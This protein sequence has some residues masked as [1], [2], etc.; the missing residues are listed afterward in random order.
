M[1]TKNTEITALVQ[2]SASQGIELSKA[3][4]LGAKFAPFMQKVQE[5]TPIAQELNYDN[6][7]QLDELKA[8]QA[9]LDLVKNRGSLGA[10][11]VKDAAK[12]GLLVE[13]KLIDS[14]YNVIVNSS[15]MLEVKFESVEKF[16]EN[17][18]LQKIESKRLERATELL[19]HEGDPTLYANLGS[20]EEEQYKA[21]LRGVVAT[22]QI[23]LEN[24][25]KLKADNEAK[26][27][28]EAER[29]A[30]IEAE[31]EALRAKQAE[32]DKANQKA[33]EEQAK[34][35][36]ENS[37][38]KA[39]LQKIIDDAKAKEQARLDAIEAENKAKAAAE[40]EAKL[41]P[42]KDKTIAY[43]NAL[44]A[45]PLPELTDSKLS[46]LVTNLVKYLLNVKNSI[47]K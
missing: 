24:E 3:Q 31:N 36:A 33:K 20:M 2:K 21:V 17:M 34:K 18:R 29:I 4:Q 19:R 28:A 25:A 42:E 40:A 47:N 39:R 22:L 9:R 45:V 27:K 13:S 8:R 46:V 30:K 43:L 35:D 10:Q 5:I 14:L 6:P 12:A 41:A 7:T 26:A 32:I 37:A 1:E 23:K 38:E 11:G 44:L 15:K 16:V